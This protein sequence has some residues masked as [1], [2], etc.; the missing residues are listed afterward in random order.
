M[1]VFRL[2]PAGSID[3]IPDMLIEGYD[4]MIWTERFQ[5]PG[6]FELKTP[7]V[8]E[9]LDLL[10]EMTLISTR[11]SK[12]VM[13]VENRLIEQD[14][15]GNW[16]LTV[17]GRSVTAFLEHR[18]VEGPYSKRRKLARKYSAT[19]ALSVLIWNV[20][21]NHTN[22]DVTREGD[23]VWTD[24][25]KI[26]NVSV[27]ESVP[28]TGDLRNWWVEEG[29]LYPQLDKIM[30]RGELGLRTIRPTPNSGNM[31]KVSIESALASRGDIIRTLVVNP[32]SLRFDIY[33][34]L[35]RSHTQTSNPVVGFNYIQGDIDNDKY[36]FSNQDYKTA[37]EVMTGVGGKD[38]YRSGDATLSGWARRVMS[39]DGGEPE[40]KKEKPTYPG[41]NASNTEQT[42]YDDDLAEWKNNKAAIDA[43]FLVDVEDDAIRALKKQRRVKLFSGDISPLAPYAYNTHYK[44]GDYVTLYGA[45]SQTERMVVSEYVR[46]E[47]AEGDRGYP[48][49]VLP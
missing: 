10:P 25:D 31:T 15:S 37:C 46:T 41:K 7:R 26:P 35:D 13:M 20:I 4:S 8:K 12:E 24:K 28:V 1:D 5:T 39:F 27:S 34:G 36:L 33:E 19:G 6:E 47:D 23:F 14:E 45:Y 49:L 18:H 29:P 40:Y 11:E 9:T 42:K 38:V 17:S 2:G 22:K 30:L 16:T 44:L 21:D 48:G 3:Y 43:E 32:T